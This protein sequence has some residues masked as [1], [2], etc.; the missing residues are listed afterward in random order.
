M[1]EYGKHHCLF[2]FQIQTIIWRWEETVYIQ[3]VRFN[4]YS[5]LY[6]LKFELVSSGSPCDSGVH[7]NQFIGNSIKYDLI[8]NDWLQ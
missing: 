7:S 1:R 5:L 2:L 3:P 6:H 4:I 8:V